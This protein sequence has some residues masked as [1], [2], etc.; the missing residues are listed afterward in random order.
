MRDEAPSREAP[1]G[2]LPA[3]VRHPSSGRRLH[4]SERG[5]GA[6]VLTVDPTGSPREVREIRTPS[7]LERVLRRVMPNE[8]MLDLRLPIHMGL[9]L[10][11]TLNDA[12][13]E[14]E[15]LAHVHSRIGEPRL[16]SVSLDEAGLSL[17]PLPDSG[18]RTFGACSS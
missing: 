16:Y 18:A 9:S 4:V 5:D 15:I 17:R 2:V 11:K 6:L 13:P 7:Q 12:C 1:T 3:A 14:A 8:V 10:L